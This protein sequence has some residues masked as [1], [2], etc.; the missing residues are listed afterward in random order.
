MIGKVYKI[1]SPD[2][3]KIYIGIT[4]KRLLCMRLSQHVFDY[5]RYLDNKHGYVSSYEIIK[6]KNYKIELL[7]EF[8]FNNRKEKHQKEKHYIDLNK[9][10]VC[11]ILGKSH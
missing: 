2:I 11:N 4:T 10:I 7:E 6:T 1:S 3:D 9:N 5:K 8:T